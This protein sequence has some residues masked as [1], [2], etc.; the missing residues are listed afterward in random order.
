MRWWW[1]RVSF[2]NVKSFRMFDNDRMHDFLG[3]QQVRGSDD[4]EVS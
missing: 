3:K 2:G 4:E 1:I